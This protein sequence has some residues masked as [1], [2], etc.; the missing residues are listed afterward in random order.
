MA[1]DTLEKAEVEVGRDIN[2]VQADLQIIRRHMRRKVQ[3]EWTDDL[4]G[5]IYGK[6]TI[7][8]KEWAV[9]RCY[10]TKYDVYRFRFYVPQE[11]SPQIARRF[12]VQAN[13]PYT[14][15]NDTIALVS[16]MRLIHTLDL[17]KD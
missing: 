3:I 9:D 5:V 2:T 11:H 7:A 13:N 1:A 4:D 17:E 14:V 8:G 12:D 16:T 10:R 6:A 15:C